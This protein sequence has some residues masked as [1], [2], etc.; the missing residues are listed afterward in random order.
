MQGLP[1]GGVG[2][3]GSVCSMAAVAN[4]LTIFVKISQVME[5]RALIL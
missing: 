3:P 4:F 2:P 5:G 1:G